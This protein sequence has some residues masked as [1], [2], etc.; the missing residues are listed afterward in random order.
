MKNPGHGLGIYALPDKPRF[1]A[2]D[3]AL[4]WLAFY[5]SGAICAAMAQ[6][7]GVGGR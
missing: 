2:C 5:T 7:I 4:C 1:L 3:S 6:K